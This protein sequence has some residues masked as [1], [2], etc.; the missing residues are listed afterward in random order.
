MIL[1]LLA[2][3]VLLSGEAV[4]PASRSKGMRG[5]QPYTKPITLRPKYPSVL[6]FC[7]CS[8]CLEYPGVNPMT[9]LPS[10]GRYLTPAEHKAH[11]S[12]D[13]QR[14][15]VTSKL[16]D[17]TPLVPVLPSPPPTLATLSTLP[18]LPVPQMTT[19]VHNVPIL[20]RPVPIAETSAVTPTK[21]EQDLSQIHALMKAIKPV[22]VLVGSS[23]VFCVPPTA[24]SSAPAYDATNEEIDELCQ[25]DP[26]TKSNSSIIRLQQLLA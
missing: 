19:P 10:D 3:C 11:I 12:R 13:Y 16:Q 22:D 20:P 4:M 5:T 23:L 14:G 7:D 2:V 15:V 26:L 6:R 9:G 21:L 18:S 24:Q 8:E 1:Y 17:L 25:L